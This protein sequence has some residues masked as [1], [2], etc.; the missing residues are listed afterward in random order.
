[1]R[2][3]RKQTSTWRGW[4]G[5]SVL[6]CSPVCKYNV[7]CLQK[8]SV[9]PKLPLLPRSPQGQ[10]ED[11]VFDG[12]AASS[13]SAPSSGTK[14]AAAAPGTSGGSYVQAWASS[15]MSCISRST[16]I[17]SSYCLNILLSPRITGDDREK[18]MNEDLGDVSRLL[19]N[20]KNQALDTNSELNR[21]NQQLDVIQDKVIDILMINKW[22]D[23]YK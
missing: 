12:K 15:N 14:T 13:G 19:G 18:Q 8:Y 22:H 3:W 20:I 21:Q 10:V 9:P 16:Y 17:L 7:I 4:R 6:A 2:I 11:A 1:M 23:K 5:G